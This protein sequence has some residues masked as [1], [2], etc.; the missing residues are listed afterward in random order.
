MDKIRTA[1]VGPG[2]GRGMWFAEELAKNENYEVVALVDRIPELAELVASKLGI[3]GAKVFA[4][5]AEALDA[6]QC[7]A[8]L[9]SSPDGE[10]VG[11]TVAALERGKHV[12]VEKPLAITL[13]DCLRIVRADKAAGM[14]TLVGFNLRFAPVYVK[15]HSAIRNGDI[16]EVLTIEADE[17]YVGGKT[18]F[19]RWNRL[20]SCGGGLWITKASHDFD[21]L[22]WMA[23]ALPKQVSAF[24][25]LSQYQ[26]KPE[27]GKRCSECAIEADCPDSALRGAEKWDD[28]MREVV[29]L[30]EKHGWYHD[31][32][33]FNSDKDTFDH[34]IAT[35]DFDSGTIGSYTVNVVSSFDERN[36]RV[37]GTCGAL[38]GYLSATEVKYWK[39]HA[40]GPP[41]MQPISGRDEADGH[42]GGDKLLLDN[43]AAFV[44]GEQSRV[45]TPAEAS[46]AV[47]MG[48]AA[49]ESSDTGR[50]VKMEQMAG[51]AELVGYLG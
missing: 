6:V 49:T 26:P 28:W 43:F 31:L 19:R 38:D 32:C 9:V 24:A 7:D 39:R 37:S 11:P 47:A 29:K 40:G 22:Y 48:L 27:A 23:G 42:G 21:L 41:E 12:Y 20:R 46:V 34:G 5:T 1:V 36:M 51:W 2:G 8:V 18:Y 16:G 50:V 44:R 25:K 3:G 4:D 17:F 30:R 14:K 33:L 45:T 10:H 15:F 35:V 13:E